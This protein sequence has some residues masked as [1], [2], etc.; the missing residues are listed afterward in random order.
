MLIEEL[1]D[2]NAEGFKVSMKHSFKKLE[3]SVT[4]AEHEIGLG[5]DDAIVNMAL[6]NL[7]KAEF[8]DH[9]LQVWFPS[10]RLELAVTDAF[11]DSH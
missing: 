1:E 9:Y 6:Y 10:H 2:A 3:L 11:K 5:S 4:R 7:L 8:G